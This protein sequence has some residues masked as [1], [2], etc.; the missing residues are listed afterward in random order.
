[1]GLSADVGWIVPLQFYVK[2]WYFIMWITGKNTVLLMGSAL[3]M[4]SLLSLNLQM[5]EKEI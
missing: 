3:S 2:Y 1:M 5:N 4:D